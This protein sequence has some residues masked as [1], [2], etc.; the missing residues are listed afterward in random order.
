MGRLKDIWNKNNFS[1]YKSDEKS[2]LKIIENINNFNGEIITEV[3]SKTDLNGNHLG[4]WQG[5]NKPTLSE[6]GMRSTVELLVNDTIPKINENINNVETY[7]TVKNN[8][9]QEAINNNK[10]I[11]LTEDLYEIT[12]TITGLEGKTIKGIEGKTKIKFIGDIDCFDLTGIQNCNIQDLEIIV[13]TNNTRN[14]F[15][16]VG[17][18]RYCYGNTIKNISIKTNGGVG[19]YTG[20]LLKAETSGVYKN[21]FI[22]ISIYNCLYGV[23]LGGGGKW[24]NMNT[25]DKISII[26]YINGIIFNATND[27][28]NNTFIRPMLEDT[29]TKNADGVD[30]DRIALKIEGRWND[31]ISPLIFNDGYGGIHYT[32]VLNE[33]SVMNSVTGGHL[34]GRVQGEEYLVFNNINTG[35]VDRDNFTTSSN[36]MLYN[37]Y[38][39]VR[40]VNILKNSNLKVNSENLIDN[41]VVQNMTIEKTIDEKSTIGY[42]TKL[43]GPTSATNSNI[44][45]TIEGYEQYKGKSLL[46]QLKLRAV[47]IPNSS[48]I[49]T[50]VDGEQVQYFTIPSRYYSTD[51]YNIISYVYTPTFTNGS[52]RVQLQVNA[53]N[54]SSEVNLEYFKVIPIKNIGNNNSM[55]NGIALQDEEIF[56][57]I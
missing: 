56:D 31:I 5:L 41:W 8:N 22:N 29:N 35:L 45:Q 52:V 2:V 42:V 18:G 28:L 36:Q 43:K 53:V 27:I 50:I 19:R 6:E 33:K 51:K 44:A 30:V 34:E 20:I 40:K 39:K 1:V 13:D 14:V 47:N 9:I 49:L 26:G 21:Q 25:F 15:K 48:L 46:F 7:K 54:P 37:N 23:V 11:L 38:G 24:V 10:S 32:L 16:G 57:I 55:L 17:Q 3:E 4:Q 12:N